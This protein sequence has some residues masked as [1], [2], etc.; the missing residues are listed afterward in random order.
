MEKVKKRIKNILEE[1]EWIVIA[2][3]SK[4]CCKAISTGLL[5][6]WLHSENVGMLMAQNRDLEKAH[7]YTKLCKSPR[8][9]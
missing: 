5:W 7:M 2:C 8:R 1:N 3:F 6:K 4:A 9:L